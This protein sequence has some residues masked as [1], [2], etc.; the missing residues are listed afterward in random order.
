MTAP[1]LHLVRESDTASWCRVGWTA[2]E[3]PA[4]IPGWRILEWREGGEP[5]APF[6]VNEPKAA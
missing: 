4:H 3:Q 1:I 6:R 2:C 5:V